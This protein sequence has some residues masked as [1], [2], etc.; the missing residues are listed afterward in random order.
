MRSREGKEQSEEGGS[1][2]TE[3][4]RERGSEAEKERSKVKREEVRQG[5]N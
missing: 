3:Q 1:E 2:A 4:V 5:G